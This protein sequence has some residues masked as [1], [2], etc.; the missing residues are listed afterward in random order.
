LKFWVV[1]LKAA[2]GNDQEKEP[3]ASEGNSEEDEA[4]AAHLVGVISHVRGG[5]IG[6][7]RAITE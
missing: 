5:I 1:I 7:I 2:Q 6:G 3:G 4:S